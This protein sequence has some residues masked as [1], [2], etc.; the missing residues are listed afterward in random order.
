VPSLF[1]SCIALLFHRVSN[2]YTPPYSQ[3]ILG[4][5]VDVLTLD[6]MVSMK[7]PAGTQPDDVLLLRNKGIK[8]LNAPT[9]R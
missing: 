5:S 3:A 2:P 7:I 6:G 8:A 4:G 1:L 9:R